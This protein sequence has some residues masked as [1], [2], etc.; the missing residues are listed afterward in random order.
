MLTKTLIKK[1]KFDDTYTITSSLGASYGTGYTIVVDDVGVTV[2]NEVGYI[3]ILGDENYG[4]VK[5]RL[6][7]SLLTKTFLEPS[8]ISKENK[9]IV[10]ISKIIKE[11]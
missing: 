9:E 2:I 5:H 11:S 10:L 4:L 6:E 3:V 1:N 7:K 8:V